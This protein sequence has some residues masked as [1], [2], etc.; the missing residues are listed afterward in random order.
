MTQARSSERASGGRSQQPLKARVYAELARGGFRSGTELAGRLAVSRSAVWKAVVAL[1]DLGV[2]VHAVRNRGYRLPVPCEL[3][4]GEK[5][6]RALAGAPGR[7]VRRID[8]AWSL[9]STNA[10][11]LEQ[12]GPP[13][14]VADVLLAEHQSAG[15]GRQGRI[16]L[17]AP[18]GALCLSLAWSFAQVPRDLGALGIAVGVWTQRALGGRATRA[19]ELKWPND[20]TVEGRKLGGILIEM[21]AES[22]GPTRVVIGI[23]I[24]LA[25]GAPA[26]AQIAAAG[27]QA[28]DL[29]AAGGDPAPRNVLAAELIAQLVMGLE[30]FERE[31]LGPFLDEWKAA[32][33]L[34][35]RLVTVH[36]G[37]AQ[38][39]GVARSID[40]GG[41]LLLE[42]RDG[43]RRFVSGEVSVRPE[44]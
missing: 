41:A 10:V 18:G 35:G 12:S 31:G 29:K 3:L 5:I 37:T 43:L 4:D 8:V 9:G 17:A 39:R 32:D 2:S 38:A 6:R 16:W 20:L 14:G 40:A 22:G 42:T 21:R 33:A 7:R 34:R 11:L 19:I 23:G 25:L 30:Q 36:A 13:P 28:T 24:N 27:T 15:R 44:P 1:R 26:L